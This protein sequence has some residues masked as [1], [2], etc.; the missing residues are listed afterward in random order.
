VSIVSFEAIKKV[1][2]G[3]ASEIAGISGAPVG[4]TTGH[5]ERPT[6]Y[7]A[8]WGYFKFGQSVGFTFDED[9]TYET[10]AEFTI[11]GAF[12]PEAEKALHPDLDDATEEEMFN[13]L[14]ARYAALKALL[15]A[16]KNA[17]APSDYAQWGTAADPRRILLPLPLVDKDGQRIA[18]LPTSLALQPGQYPRVVEYR[19]TLKEIKLPAAKLVINGKIIDDAVVNVTCPHPILYRHS[20][21]GCSGEVIQ[22]GNYTVAEYDISGTTP[23]PVATD[24]LLT[25]DNKTLLKEL[26]NNQLTVGVVR[27]AAAGGQ[28]VGNND[29]WTNLDVDEGSGADLSLHEPVLNW[30]IKAKAR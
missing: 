14:T 6:L 13:A 26:G 5:A 22:V 23:N 9:E 3:E 11:E 10:A 17:T 20:L 15:E 29:L 16:A 30:A 28:V 24:D 21:V 7:D 1:N 4:P 8:D 2:P 19:A 18:T 25:D 27:L 12:T